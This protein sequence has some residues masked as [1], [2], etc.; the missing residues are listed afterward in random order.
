MKNVFI[1][2]IVLIILTIPTYS[3]D[4]NYVV[5]AIGQKVAEAYRVWPNH[6]I[7]ESLGS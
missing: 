6:N 5:S 4:S 1:I 3:Q 7:P 2:T